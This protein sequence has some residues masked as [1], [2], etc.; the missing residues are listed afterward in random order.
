MTVNRI[1]Y[2][3]AAL[4]ALA[5]CGNRVPESNPGVGFQ[6]YTQYSQNQAGLTNP[7]AVSSAPLGTPT[8]T[9]GAIAASDLNAVGIG[10]AQTQTYGNSTVAAAG[11]TTNDAFAAAGRGTGLDAS[12]MNATTMTGHSTISDEQSFE[13][14]SSRETIESDAQRRAAMSAQYQVIQPTALPTR[15]DD[16]VNI[17]Q[18]ALTAPN[19]KGQEWYSRFKFSGQGRFERNCASYNTPDDA[20]RD[21]L[22]R[23]GPDRDPKGIDPDGDGFACGWDPAPFIAAARAAN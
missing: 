14:V 2:L 16:A 21:F 23:G 11:A 18:Y 10:A 22:S 17:V 8:V 6:D 12:P 3:G 9:G 1:V 20:Q 5:S 4:M 19:A 15:H 7:S 13:A